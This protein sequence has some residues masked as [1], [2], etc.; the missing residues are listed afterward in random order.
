MGWDWSQ[1]ASSTGCRIHLAYI[2]NLNFQHNHPLEKAKDKESTATIKASK[3]KEENLEAAGGECWRQKWQ[4]LLCVTGEK[5]N[6]FP[7]KVMFENIKAIGRKY[8]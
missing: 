1:G 3:V 8:L 5:F 6:S 4:G 2:K 7:L